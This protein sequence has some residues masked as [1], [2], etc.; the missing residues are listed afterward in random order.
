M[1]ELT[2][3]QR[4]AVASEG[5][6]PPRV[7]DPVTQTKYVLVREEV[8]NQARR[9]FDD[10]DEEFVRELTPDVMKIFGRDGWDDP[11]MDVYNELDP[12]NS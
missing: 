7:L 5:E 3:E 2:L 9:V 4:K 8:Y 6:S 12:R 10:D 11:A 1:I